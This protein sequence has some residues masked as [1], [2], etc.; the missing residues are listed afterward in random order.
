MYVCAS[1]IHANICISGKW[2]FVLLLKLFDTGT[3]TSWET[4]GT[5]STTH[6]WKNN[7][8]QTTKLEQRLDMMDNITK[9]SKQTG[10]REYN[11][12]HLGKSK[13]YCFLIN[14]TG[15]IAEAMKVLAV[16][17]SPG[18]AQAKRDARSPQQK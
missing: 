14:K 15:S 5:E 8:S 3:K 12:K 7:N 6:G 2:T 1:P 13:V 9:H 10:S 4:N 18:T 17:K 16:G 11:F